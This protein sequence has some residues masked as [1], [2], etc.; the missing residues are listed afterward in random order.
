MKKIILLGATGSIG[1][2]TLDVIRAN[3]D[4]FRL[5]AMSF[6]E[7]IELGLKAVHEFKPELVAVKNREIYDQI[8]LNIPS[9]CQLT[10]GHDGLCETA[11]YHKGEIVVN[12]VIGSVGLIPTL[13]AIEAK[14]TVA[15]A[16]KETLVTA[17]QI[18]TDYARKHNVQILPVDSEHSAIFQC[19]NGEKKESVERL[20]LTA[21]GGSFRDKS[22]N[23][24]KHVT[25]KEALNHP[26]WSMGAK[27]TI[28]SATMMNKG[29]EVIEAHWLFSVS[30]DQIDVLLH[31]ESVIHS[32]VEF[33]DGSII[34]QL[35][36]PDMKI[37]I[38][39]ALTYPNR[40][41]SYESERLDLTKYGQLHFEKIDFDRY[42]CLK[43]AFDSG[44]IGGTMPAVLNAAN[45]VAVNAFLEDKIPFLKIEELVERA[46]EEHAPLFNPTLEDIQEADGRTRQFV[47][48]LIN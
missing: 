3:P 15:L 45:E 5:V 14:K 11:A 44:K 16:N 47:Q 40:I 46:L 4:S 37:P 8:R 12:A 35:G 24:L 48:S 39:Y 32:M 21:S 20:I 41:P 2:Q 10:Y 6:G 23:E 22:R 25:V 13:K 1:Q 29:L 19:L 42:R 26:N 31:K 28:D 7:N 30:Y 9:N 17:G 43:F 36:T 34:A 27:I 18:V 33:H 38:Q